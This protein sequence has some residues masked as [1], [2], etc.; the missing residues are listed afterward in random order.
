MKPWG[1]LTLQSGRAKMLGNAYNN[2]LYYSPY[3]CNNNAEIS[4]P[5]NDM[6]KGYLYDVYLNLSNDSLFIVH[7]DINLRV[8]SGG[9]YYLNTGACLFLGTVYCYA[10]GQCA[11][12]PY[13]NSPYG[14]DNILGVFNAY[15]R[16]PVL[17]INRNTNSQWQYANEGIRYADNSNLFR[18]SWVDGL[19]DVYCRGKYEVS[20][21]GVNGNPSAATVGVGLDY[22]GYPLN[23]NGLLPQSAMISEHEG[24]QISGWDHTDGSPGLHSWQAMEQTTQVP[25]NFFG[26][27]FACLTAELC[28]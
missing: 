6:L 10:D 9:L 13:R 16:T 12:E 26:N 20:V 3:E 2:V 24:M 11:W 19:G 1:K 27:N 14:G 8:S 5:L 21:S 22:S 23:W 17:A 25:V 4:V 7:F 15:N 28:L 18:I